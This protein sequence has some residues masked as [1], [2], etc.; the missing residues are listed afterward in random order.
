MEGIYEK[1]E[2]KE[3]REKEV[4]RK[5][6]AELHT[7]LMELLSDYL[8]SQEHV[9][10]IPVDELVNWSYKQMQNPE[11][12]DKEKVDGQSLREKVEQTKIDSS[13]QG[14]ERQ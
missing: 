8:L 6:H 10:T 2:F 4:H 11:H 9:H 1:D 3:L 14:N 7:A 5:R 13:K 12:Q